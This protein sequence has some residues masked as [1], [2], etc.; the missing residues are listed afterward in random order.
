MI[1]LV[2]DT[3]LGDDISDNVQQVNHFRWCWFRNRDNFLKEGIRLGNNKLYNR[4]LEFMMEQYYTV[5]Q[6]DKNPIIGENIVKLW[7]YIFDYTNSNNNKSKSDID[8]FIEMYKLLEDSLI[9][10]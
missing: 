6:K 10:E 4:F 8:T 1:T 3:Y 7:G 9:A 5:A 2:F